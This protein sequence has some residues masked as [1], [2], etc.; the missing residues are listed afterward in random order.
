MFHHLGRIAA[1]YP[2]TICACWLIAGVSLALTAPHWDTRC[3]DDDICFLPERFTSLR[4]FHLLE[5]AFPQDVYAS[6]VV[7][8]LE[9]DEA[10]LSD[11]NFQL[12]DQIVADL[13]KLRQDAPELKIGKVES[14]QDDI[15]G[16]R[17]SSPDQRCT[18][19]QVSLGTPY[20]AVCTAQAVD[21]AQTVVNQRLARVGESAPAV[22]T[23]GA[24]GLGHD[25]TTACGASLEHTTW[26]TVLL[27]VIVL[28]AVYRAPLM[29][30]IPLATIACSVWVAL[31]MLALMTLLP[32]V[33]L[34]NIS[35][36]FAIVILYGAGTDYCLFLISRYREELQAGQDTEGA[37][38][39]GVSGVG[40]AL[41]ASAG[42]V[43]VGLGLMAMAEF[44]KVRYAGPAIALSLGVA[45]LAS[46]T[47]TPALLRLCGAV[48]FWP[49][50]APKLTVKEKLLR[51]LNVGLG[52]WDWMSRRVA[53]RPIVVWCVASLILAPLVLIGLRTQPSYRATSELSP[54][55]PSLRGLA[56]IQRHFNA[57]DIGPVTVLLATTGDWDSPEGQRQIDHLS[58]GF[59]SLPNVAEVRSLT[60]PLGMPII[61]LTPDLSR[62][63]LVTRL[64]QFIQPA[65]EEIRATM[66][67]RAAEHYVAT[68]DDGRNVTRLDVVLASDPFEPASAETLKLIETWLDTELP[69][70]NLIGKNI[71]AECYGITACSQD[72]AE[73]T[74]GDRRRVNA[75]VIGAILLILLVLVRRWVLTLYLLATVLASYYAALGA[76]V[77]AGT[78][79]TGAPLPALDWRVPFFLF[80]ILVAVGEDYNILLVSRALQERKKHGSVEG[81]RRALAKTGGAITSC[82]LIMAGTFA[83]L[84]LNGLSTLMQIG[85]ALACGVLIDTFLVRPFLVPA[86]AM[87][88][89]REAKDPAPRQA[90]SKQ[91]VLLPMIP[92]PRKKVA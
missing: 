25:L 42:T 70:F 68:G 81:M 65:L 7:F 31:N 73:V 87:L 22:Y 3:Q 71:Q 46:L 33:H 38:I 74:E 39:R 57:G 49:R 92:R 83:T 91:A 10:P 82:G 88:F 26:A 62:D 24:A 29:A 85:F 56:A 80:T 63:C 50:S 90:N 9:R 52:F 2:W 36:I 43:M 66:H 47:L 53:A 69:H 48:A 37:I 78:L 76:T 51:K 58:R 18:L 60:Q 8:A 1:K 86:F 67:A 20:L 13:E 59:A 21:R 72:L 89:W 27:V 4:A 41:T 45:L 55:A 23:T 75:L 44:A 17:L 15:V 34:V 32:G 5:Q 84:M 30:L 12:V 61:D 35:K 6:R 19:I 64:L 14:Y 40:T 28:L 16:A 77:L 79:W 54:Q 11:A